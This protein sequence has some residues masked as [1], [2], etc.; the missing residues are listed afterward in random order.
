MSEPTAVNVREAIAC[1]TERRTVPANT[2]T[3]AFDE[4]MD[5][6]ASPVQIAALLVALRVKGEEVSEMPPSGKLAP[7]VI[8][9]F[10]KWVAMGAPDPRTDGSKVVE[11]DLQRL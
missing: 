11:A 1:V 7:E 8:A 5:G 9:N 3:A 6:A 2:L 4:I 10:E